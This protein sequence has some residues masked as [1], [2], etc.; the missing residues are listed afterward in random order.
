MISNDDVFVIDSN[1]LDFA[2]GIVPKIRFTVIKASNAMLL[3]PFTV[4]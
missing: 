4:E 1:Y 3:L 2:V